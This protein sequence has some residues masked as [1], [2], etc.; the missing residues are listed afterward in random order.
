MTVQKIGKI[1]TF[2]G[3][4]LILGAFGAIDCGTITITRFIIAL[5]CRIA[6]TLFGIYLSN[7]ENPDEYT[8]EIEVD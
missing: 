6:I 2:V 7:Y 3:A 1:I 5:V 4:L 8:D